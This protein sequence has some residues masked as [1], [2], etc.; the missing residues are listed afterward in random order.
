MQLTVVGSSYL[1][2]VLER[3]GRLEP[4]RALELVG[5]VA[6]LLDTACSSRGPVHETSPRPTSST[7]P[8]QAVARGSSRC[9]RS[10]VWL[11]PG[12]ALLLAVTALIPASLAGCGGGE[13]KAPVGEPAPPA[14]EPERAAQPGAAETETEPASGVSVAVADSPWGPI[15]VDTTPCKSDELLCEEGEAL[16]LDTRDPPGK[17][18]CEGACLVGTP[19]FTTDGAPRA[20]EGVDA[21]LLGT[22]T[23]AD[24]STQVTY[25]GHPLYRCTVHEGV[26]GDTNCRGASGVMFLITVAGDPQTVTTEE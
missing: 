21:S 10:P 1:A 20:G 25:N 16:Y 9:A 15:L 7:P 8:P 26:E 17:S 19:P 3:Q 22:T 2:E 24:G 23:R 11:K 4:G 5:Q 13:T 18:V 12:I 6:D 14:A